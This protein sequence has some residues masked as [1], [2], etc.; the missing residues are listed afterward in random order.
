MDWDVPGR[1]KEGPETDWAVDGRLREG[2]RCI[3]VN[4][5]A[6]TSVACGGDGFAE[7]EPDRRRDRDESAV[8]GR[9]V[10]TTLRRSTVDA[11]DGGSE[12]SGGG[13]SRCIAK[14]CCFSSS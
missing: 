10:D 4:G 11:D 3:G 8:D 6:K 7:T 5:V 12:V 14:R 9:C 2:G 13:L 1:L